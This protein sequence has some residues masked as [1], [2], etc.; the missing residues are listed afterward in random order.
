VLHYDALE[1]RRGNVRIPHSIRIDDHDWTASANAET[2]RFSPFYAVGSEEKSLAL[3]QRCKLRVKLAPA[4]V[5]RAKASCADDDVAGIRL[6][7]GVTIAGRDSMLA[8]AERSPAR[9][10]VDS[11][12]S[13]RLFPILVHPET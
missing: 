11:R 13:L 4:T 6:H 8:H 5:R 1:Q 7:N 3:K 9:P 2:W 10:A 12:A